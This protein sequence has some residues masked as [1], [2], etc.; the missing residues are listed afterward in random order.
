MKSTAL[1][2][3]N[4]PG[5]KLTWTF[6]I[7]GC[8]ALLLRFGWV[9]YKW[10]LDELEYQEAIEEADRLDPG[11][12]LADLEAARVLIPD[13]ENSALQVLEAHR[14]MP[15]DWFSAPSDGSDSLES[16]LD[17]LSPQGRLN[18]KQAKEL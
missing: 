3:K 17:E 18:E 13:E 10:H 5:R 1:I 8:C 6:T 4:R 11:W 12:R 16:I 9:H 14:Q 15:K 2:S 7:V